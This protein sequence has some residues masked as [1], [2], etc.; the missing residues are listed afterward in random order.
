MNSHILLAAEGE[1]ERV[2]EGF[3]A[4]RG[5]IA[6]SEARFTRFSAD[7]EL[8]QLNRSAG[9]WF[10]ASDAMYEVAQQARKLMELTCGLFDP[11]I[12]GAL[13]QAGYDRS[14][15]EIRAGGGILPAPA[16]ARYHV[17]SPLG[18]SAVE[19]KPAIHG[20]HLPDEVQIDLGGIAKGWIAE[21]TV[22]VLSA[23]A[24][25]CAVSAG[26]DMFMHR[27]P[28]GEQ[29]WTVALEDPR[30][31]QHT[32]S[33]L[34]VQ[35][36]AVATSSVT[37]RR[38]LQGRQVQ[39]H[40]IDPRS[41]MPAETDWLS[42]TVVADHMTAAEAFAK[43]ILIAGSEYAQALADRAAGIEFIGVKQ[44]GSLWGSRHSKELLDVASK[45]I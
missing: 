45:V 35:A 27:L 24:Q 15:D 43:A 10:V 2:R 19:F 39:H 23:Y 5:F 37:L 9:G 8:A 40:I 13:R 38:W 44:D 1:P 7:S 34:H 26:G 3:R 28:E 30:D 6:E 31:P 36:G 32:L 20:I 42:M 21:Q 14:M 41:G 33:V 11:S 12:L 22:N 18:F 16:A 17:R 4:A 25:A 29:T